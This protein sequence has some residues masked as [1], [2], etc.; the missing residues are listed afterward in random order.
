[1]EHGPDHSYFDMRKILQLNEFLVDRLRNFQSI[2][3]P[4]EACENLIQ[5]YEN[6]IAELS[7]KFKYSRR[8]TPFK[9]WITPAILCC[10]NRKNKLYKKFV[11]KRTIHNETKY[12]QYRNI[13]TG[14]IRDAKRIYFKK[15]FEECK[16]DGK[17]NLA[18]HWRSTK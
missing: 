1:M 5:A 4:H 2:T 18:D 3:D 16:G 7:R 12:K 8:N 14:I 6:G 15:A 13:L 9:P 17:K 11:N 10:I